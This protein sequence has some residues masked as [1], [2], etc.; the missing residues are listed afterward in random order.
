[1][2]VAARGIVYAEDSASLSEAHALEHAKAAW[3]GGAVTTALELIERSIQSHPR[4][5]LLHKLRGDILATFRGPQEAVQAYEVALTAEPSAV[6]VR[7]AKWSLLVRW[8]Q[9]DEAIAE[10]RRIARFDQTNPL[11]HLKLAQ[12]L[13]KLD[14]LE[15]SL[16]SYQQAVQLRPDLL[17][18]R[19]AMAR[20]QFDVLDYQGAEAGVRN[21]HLAH[22]WRS[23]PRTSSRNCTNPWNGDGDSFLR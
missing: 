4:S 1:L 9:Y 18:W 20:A 19:L 8:G 10:L 15:E 17:G 12:E 3:D 14:R 2:A 22:H 5:A 11:A 7:W 16:E 23:R 21:S 13:R 6:D